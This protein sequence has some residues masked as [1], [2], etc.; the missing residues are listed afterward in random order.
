MEESRAGAACH[1]HLCCPRINPHALGS[2]S[3]GWNPKACE[4]LYPA[5]PADA[6]PPLPRSGAAKSPFCL[7]WSSRDT[8]APRAGPVCPTHC[9]VPGAHNS[10]CSLRGLTRGCRACTHVCLMAAG[11]TSEPL[12]RAGHEDWEPPPPLPWHQQRCQLLSHTGHLSPPY[13]LGHPG[14]VQGTEKPTLMAPQP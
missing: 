6:L 9:C 13:I 3:D 14:V 1:Q 8:G 5:T 10:V 2:S 4:H 7:A 12:P 11:G